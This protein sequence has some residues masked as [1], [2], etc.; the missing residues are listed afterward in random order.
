MDDMWIC[1]Y[2]RGYM[3]GYT[4]SLLEVLNGA[5]VLFGRVSS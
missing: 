3:R 1:G 4:T 5:R 2:M